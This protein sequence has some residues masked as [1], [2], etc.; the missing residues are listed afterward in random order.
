MFYI[1]WTI[2]K[3]SNICLTLAA[4]KCLD[5]THN[6]LTH[7]PGDF[8]NLQHL[9]QLYLR[10]NQLSGIPLLKNCKNLKVYM[11]VFIKKARPLIEGVNFTCTK[12]VMY[13]VFLYIV[14]VEFMKINVYF[15]VLLL[16]TCA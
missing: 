7:L 12:I 3:N 8:G 5:V 4:L 10:H 15:S 11:A 1:F 6:Q 13:M 14:F 2:F 9:E 16:H